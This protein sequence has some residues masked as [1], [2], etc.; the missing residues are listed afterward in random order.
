MLWRERAR[1]PGLYY[2]RVFGDPTVDRIG[3]WRFGAHHVSLNYLVVQGEVRAVAPC[4][5]GADP[6]S[7]PAL[8][9]TTIRPLA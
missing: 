5:R 9:G 3:A 4:F 2:L 7:A 6:G 8:G 1:D